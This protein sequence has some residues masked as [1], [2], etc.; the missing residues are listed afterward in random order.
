[1]SVEIY[2]VSEACAAAGQAWY[3]AILI[4]ERDRV[5]LSLARASLRGMEIAAEQSDKACE[6]ARRQFDQAQRDAL[7]GSD[8]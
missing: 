5:T 2:A 3:D 7:L 1:M 6:E 8:R 4:R